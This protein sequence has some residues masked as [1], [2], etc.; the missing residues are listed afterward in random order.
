[1]KHFYAISI[2]HKRQKIEL[3]TTTNHIAEDVETD[4]RRNIRVRD[5]NRRWGG[6][7]SGQVCR[8]PAGL[9]LPEPRVRTQEK[10]NLNLFSLSQ[11]QWKYS[12]W[13]SMFSI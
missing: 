8:H 3:L 9:G 4:L 5:E 2:K 10:I 6:K 11:N 7:V 1:M 12:L 13:L